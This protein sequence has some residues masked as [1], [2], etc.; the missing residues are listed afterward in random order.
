MEYRKNTPPTPLKRGEDGP[1][2]PL[3]RGEQRFV[4]TIRIICRI[5][6]GM[7]FVFSGF[8]KGIDPWGFTYKIRDY[9]EAFHLDFL[10]GL[11]FPL[12]VTACTLEL[13]I[14]L[15]L[16]TGIRMRVTSWFLLL[17]MAFFTILT[18]VLAL[19]N[20]VSDCGCFGD[21]IKLTNWQTFWKNIILL[22]PAVIVFLQRNRF[23]SLYACPSEWTLAAS[24]ALLGVLLSV[25][26]YHN[27]PL[28]DFRPY[29]TG[30]YIPGKMKIPEGMPADVYET[31]LV[32]E[33]DGVQKEFTAENY[34]WQDTTWGWKE[35]KQK[36]VKKGYETPINDF[37]ITSSGGFDITGEILQDT[38]Y[39][40]LIV[41]YDLSKPN[42]TAFGMLNKAAAEGQN[43][44]YTYY[45]LTSSTQEEIAAFRESFNPAYEIC[46][47]D[48]ITLKTIIRANPGIV[49]LRRG[50]ILG[51]WHHRNFRPA[52]FRE[53]QPDAVVLT[54]FRR[55][56]EKHRIMLTAAVFLLG[57]ML[58]HHFNRR[59]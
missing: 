37:L 52:G 22:V 9:F 48:E 30:T 38:G 16:L 45:L 25:Y 12:A 23:K 6:T 28:M 2:A 59:T 24:F 15:N 47:A 33:K 3:K 7:V 11:A 13:V 17:F 5:V 55:S 41:A 54:G 32:Y 14:G 10:N 50:T 31:I 49:L 56:L 18:L 34:P 19:F 42:R 21:A 58:F 57:L 39:T 1:P 53:Q 20:P 26:C 40:F 4:N 51:K 8:V 35:T 27:L 43:E 29:S 46:T 44:G 36:L